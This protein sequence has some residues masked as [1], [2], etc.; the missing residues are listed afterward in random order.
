M[1]ERAK[2]AERDGINSFLPSPWEKNL[3]PTM[4]MSVSTVQHKQK[5]IREYHK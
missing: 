4:A 3:K 2:D 5:Y 1:Y